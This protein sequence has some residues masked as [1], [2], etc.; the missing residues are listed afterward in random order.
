MYPRILF[1]YLIPFSSAEKKQIDV[2]TLLFCR[3][4]LSAQIVQLY[5]K[6]MVKVILLLV[7]EYIYDALSDLVSDEADLKIEIRNCT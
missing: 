3:A 4:L 6:I 1:H 7:L 5:S 2:K